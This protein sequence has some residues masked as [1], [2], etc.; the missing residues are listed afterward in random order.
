MRFAINIGWPSMINL[1]TLCHTA[2]SKPAVTPKQV[3][4]TS[5]GRSSHRHTCLLLSTPVPAMASHSAWRI[6]DEA[7]LRWYARRADNLSSTCLW[8]ASI[9]RQS[10]AW[11]GNTGLSTLGGNGRGTAPLGTDLG[12]E[13]NFGRRYSFF[14]NSSAHLD[15]QQSE[16]TK[17]YQ[18]CEDA[19]PK[20]QRVTP[21]SN[22]QQIVRYSEAHLG[23]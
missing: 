4:S 12:P 8:A 14:L 15:L 5:I 20:H 17:Q 6:K 18:R 13:K 23:R 10:S 1:F 22:H 7:A 2:I 9:A 19:E 11:G 21:L 16:H 3:R